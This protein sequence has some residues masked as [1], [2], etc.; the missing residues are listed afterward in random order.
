MRPLWDAERQANPQQP[1]R[2]PWAACHCDRE[3]PDGIHLLAFNHSETFNLC[4]I[5]VLL[6]QLCVE[7]SHLVPRGPREQQALSDLRSLLT[8]LSVERLRISR[9]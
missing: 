6:A 3:H 9:L 2:M 5:C 4:P 8:R 7:V 1:A